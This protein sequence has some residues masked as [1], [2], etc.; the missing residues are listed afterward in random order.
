MRK[1]FIKIVIKK[2]KSSL[3]KYENFFNSIKT[4]SVNYI[5]NTHDN[6]ISNIVCDFNKNCIFTRLVISDLTKN[7]TNKYCSQSFSTLENDKVETKK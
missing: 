1:S 4:S 3:E 5:I 2:N 7:K 6:T